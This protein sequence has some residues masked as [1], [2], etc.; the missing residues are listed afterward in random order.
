MT[1]SL[2]R[3]LSWQLMCWGWASYSR[4]PLELKYAASHSGDGRQPQQ[5]RALRGKEEEGE[6]GLRLGEEWGRPTGGGKGIF[7]SNC[8]L[9]RRALK[10]SLCPRRI[11]ALWP[12]GTHQTISVS[13]LMLSWRS[14][15]T[16]AA[17]NSRCQVSGGV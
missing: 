7:R 11:V 14:L 6:A 1:S 15:G 10:P 2:A 9:W 17:T 12:N 4:G 8:P 5:D 13:A 16:V 3:A